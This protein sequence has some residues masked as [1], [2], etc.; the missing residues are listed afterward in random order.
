MTLWK[1]YRERTL[2]S[3]AGFAGAILVVGEASEG[4]A[5]APSERDEGHSP[6]PGQIFQV[7]PDV[8]SLAMSP[9]PRSDSA[10]FSCSITT[11]S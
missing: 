4:A 2:A 6:P 11:S 8:R 9:G 1:A 10:R 7:S 3:S 5:E